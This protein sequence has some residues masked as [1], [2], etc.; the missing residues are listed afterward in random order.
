MSASI[1]LDPLQKQVDAA[2]RHIKTDGYTMSVGELMSLYEHEE[3]HIRPEFQRLFRWTSH[4]QTALI[5]SI[6]LGIPL[7]SI[8]VSQRPDGVW[9]VVDG[10]QRLTTIFG[11]AGILREPLGEDLASNG[12]GEDGETTWDPIRELEGTEYLP[13]LEGVRWEPHEDGEEGGALTSAQRMMIKRAKMDVKIVLEE[14]SAE[15]KY[16]LFMRL[17]TLGSRLSDQEVRNCLLVWTNVQAFRWFLHLSQ[18][19]SFRVCI[20][21]TERDFAERYDMELA[22]RFVVL[23]NMPLDDLKGI[24]DLGAFLTSRMREFAENDKFPYEVEERAFIQ[25]F[26]ALEASL[27]A[28]SFRKWDEAKGRFTGGFLISAFEAIAFGLGQHIERLAGCVETDT[29][30]CAVERVWAS[31]VFQKGFPG[32]RASQRLPRTLATGRE[33]FGKLLDESADS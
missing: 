28:D 1:A 24:A 6:L 10:L 9:E 16:D 4:Q 20:P 27:G 8:F 17:N 2:R 29:L 33:E 23:R 14:S 25:T 21:L 15:A 19:P 18:V 26:G 31:D 11:F 5:E 30:R 32:M 3:L 12:N 13:A 7:P 22:L